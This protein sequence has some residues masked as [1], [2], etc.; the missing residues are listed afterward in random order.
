MDNGNQ[1]ELKGGCIYRN[2]RT[3]KLYRFV[4]MIDNDNARFETHFEQ[5]VPFHVGEIE[6]TDYESVKAFRDAV[7]QVKENLS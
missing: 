7:N 5:P 1:T 2:T 6:K 3:K 4:E